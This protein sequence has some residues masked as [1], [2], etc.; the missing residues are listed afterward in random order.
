MNFYQVGK[1][2][3]REL[4]FYLIAQNGL[5][6]ENRFRIVVRSAAF[7]LRLIPRHST[8]RGAV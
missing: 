3:D 8:S 7:A 5:R 2:K 4:D 6:N 1:S